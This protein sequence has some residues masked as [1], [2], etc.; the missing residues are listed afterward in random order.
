VPTWVVRFDARAAGDRH[1]EVERI[2][3]DI[4]RL[5]TKGVCYEFY[6]TQTN[7]VTYF[8]IPVAK[9]FSIQQVE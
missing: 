5:D 1:Q 3:A 4:C 7:S 9:I 6:D 2:E 8:A